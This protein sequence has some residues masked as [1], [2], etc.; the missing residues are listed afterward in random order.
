MTI[1]NLI[2]F[3]AWIQC[4][5]S[6][7]IDTSWDLEFQA[8]AARSLAG[9]AGG[10]QDAGGSPSLS[11]SAVCSQQP[12]WSSLNQGAVSFFC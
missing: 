1:L 2:E 11:R 5:M 9:S 8:G 4:V 6:N 12:Q 10:V 3:H 7:R